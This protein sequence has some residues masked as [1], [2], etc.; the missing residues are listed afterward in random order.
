YAV[1]AYQ[2]LERPYKLEQLTEVL[3]VLGN[4]RD[5]LAEHEQHA[6][7]HRHVSGLH[8]RLDA[9]LQFLQNPENSKLLPWDHH[10]KA[11]KPEVR[12][13][14]GEGD[15]P[16]AKNPMIVYVTSVGTLRVMLYQDNAP[17]AVAHVVSLVEEG[18]YDRSQA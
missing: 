12:L 6:S 15:D 2:L 1:R 10:S 4:A 14:S 11:D 7:W 9:D 17:N 3:G 13:V 16:Q 18:F 8:A 5:T